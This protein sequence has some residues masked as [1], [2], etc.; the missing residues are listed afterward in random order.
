MN[1]ILPII[2]TALGLVVGGCSCEREYEEE[3]LQ[4][5]A[6]CRSEKGRE[7]IEQDYATLKAIME[8]ISNYCGP[9]LENGC[10]EGGCFEASGSITKP[11]KRMMTASGRV[12]GE[13]KDVPYAS[14]EMY[15]YAGSQASGKMDLAKGCFRGVIDRVAE[16]KKNCSPTLRQ[17]LKQTVPAQQKF[18]DQDRRMRERTKR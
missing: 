6:N 8:E 16:G 14:F 13:I 1:K 7:D 12:A 11:Y 2:V 4:I 3:D 18:A 9:I 17:T 10:G 15:T 5:D